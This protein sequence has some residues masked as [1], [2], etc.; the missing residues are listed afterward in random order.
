MK[1]AILG[2]TF[3]PPHWAHLFLAEEVRTLLGYDRIVFVPA[4]LPAHKEVATDI[5]P[6]QRWDML[7]QAL[8]GWP[9]FI[10]DSCEIDRGGATYSI[11]TV[12]K[13]VQKYRI[14]GKPGFII[15]DDLLAGFASWKRAGELAE[16]VDLIVAHRSHRRRKA[17]AFPHRYIDN[18][19]LPISSSDIRKRIRNNEAVRFLVP[20]AVWSYIEDN[21]L[22]R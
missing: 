18:L 16:S 13:L 10:A 8:E 20:E 22:Y 21:A 2:G 17:F 1:A 7:E 12:P 3:N 15:G 11:E 5:S 9:Y 19:M 14:K 6:K 4:N